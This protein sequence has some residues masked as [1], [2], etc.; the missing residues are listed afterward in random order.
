[1]VS[2]KY[3]AYSRQADGND[4]TPSAKL[5]SHSDKN[6]G[7]KIPGQDYRDKTSHMRI[8]AKS[9]ILSILAVGTFG[10]LYKV[11]YPNHASPVLTFHVFFIKPDCYYVPSSRAVS[12]S[13]LLLEQR[14][15]TIHQGA[16]CT[17]GLGMVCSSS[18]LDFPMLMIN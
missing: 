12:T 7:T 13:N 10:K 17:Y 18:S 6:T 3:A 4:S 9:F 16:A 15:L 5:H 8:D 11:R 2:G 1:M 14:G